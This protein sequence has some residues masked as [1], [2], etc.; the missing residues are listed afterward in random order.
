MLSKHIDRAHSPAV[1][2]SHSTAASS[3]CFH[4][5]VALDLTRPINTICYSKAAAPIAAALTNRLQTPVLTFPALSVVGEGAAAALLPDT[6]VGS[7]EPVPLAFANSEVYSVVRTPVPLLHSPPDGAEAL[8][9]M[10]AH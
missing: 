5:I 10:S 8:K 9:V 3:K 6:T 7:A 1:F 4:F 2:D